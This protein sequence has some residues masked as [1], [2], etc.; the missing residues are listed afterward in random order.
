MRSDCRK[1]REDKKVKSEGKMR[2]KFYFEKHVALNFD[3]KKGGKKNLGKVKGKK[4][5]E[6][7][8]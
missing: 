1:K 4:K 8:D 6:R 3:E 7:N 5:K 2:R